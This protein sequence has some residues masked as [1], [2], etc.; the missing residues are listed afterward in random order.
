MG[1][2]FM[3][4]MILN[5]L[6][7]GFSSVVS[8]NGTF[9]LLILAAVALFSG[10]RMNGLGE[11]PGKTAQSLLIFGAGLFAYEGLMSPERLTLQNWESAAMNSWDGLMGLE[12]QTL[13]GYGATFLLALTGVYGIK[14]IARR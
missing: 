10:M 5:D 4:D 7:D 6:M 14:L 8:G 13:V 12:G 2:L 3:L 11:L 9:T 1:G